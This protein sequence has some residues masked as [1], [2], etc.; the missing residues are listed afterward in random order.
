[1][2][3]HLKAVYRKCPVYGNRTALVVAIFR[4]EV[5]LIAEGRLAAVA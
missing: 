2:K 1:V 5:K 3:Q 4:D